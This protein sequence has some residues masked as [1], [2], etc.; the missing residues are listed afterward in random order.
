MNTYS[1]REAND[2]LAGKNA[3]DWWL[4]AGVRERRF[5]HY[6][7]GKRIRFTDDHLN[8]IIQQLERPAHQPSAGFHTD[9]NERETGMAAFG[10]ISSKKHTA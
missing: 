8:A 9:K 1:V 2:E 10:S 4:R 7:V 6:R 5:P 3:S